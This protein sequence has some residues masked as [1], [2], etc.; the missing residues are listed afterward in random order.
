MNWT[1]QGLV[2]SA[3]GQHAWM[4]SHASLP[5]SL[6]L[7]GDIYRIYFASRDEKNRSHV[8][9]VEIDI[10]SPKDIL[11]ISDK[12]V[13]EP[14]PLGFFDDHGVYAASIVRNNEQL[15]LYYIG[16]NPGAKGP[17]FYSSIG[18]ASSNDGGLTFHKMFKSPIMARSE[19]D[20][21]L[22]TSPCVINDGGRWRMWYVSGFKWEEEPDG[23]HSYYHIKYA[24]S[25]DGIKWERNG[26]VAIDHK[27]GEKNIARPCVTRDEGL[28]RMWYSF[29]ADEGYRIGYA[30]SADGYSWRRKD[31]E[32]GIGVSHEGW[33][34]RALAYP[35]VFS[36]KGKRYM[37]YNG[38]DF[39]RE[40]FGL[41]VES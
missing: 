12:P 20:P 21:C 22:V 17:L 11:R 6:L 14:G 28:Y 4:R 13:L 36:H 3:S 26:L 5:V 31:D 30:E 7:E 39:G 41:A 35:W 29:N 10:N 27:P 25:A 40:G 23:L 18:L 34:S 24:E 15:F 1:K 33:D 32:V 9:F 16:W 38:N 8:S 37:L 19:Y 2:L